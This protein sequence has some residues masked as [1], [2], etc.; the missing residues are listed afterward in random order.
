MIF[1]IDFDGTV[2]VEDGR[3]YDGLDEPLELIPGAREGLEALRAAGHILLLYSARANRSLREDPYYDPLVR[4]G[5]RKIDV[6]GWGLMQA[7]HESRYREMVDFVRAELPGIFHAI[8][9]G[10]QGKPEVDLIIDN[11]ALRFGLSGKQG[12]LGWS[13]IADAYGE[14]S[15]VLQLRQEA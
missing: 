2:V 4:L 15:N 1:A 8:D 10:H 9:D 7:L 3:P 12:A 11:R 14:R 5:V 13:G 6:R